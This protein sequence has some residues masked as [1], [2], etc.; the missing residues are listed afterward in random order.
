[1]NATTVTATTSRPAGNGNSVTQPVDAAIRLARAESP[2]VRQP[3]SLGSDVTQEPWQ[4]HLQ[5]TIDAL[6]ASRV[7]LATEPFDEVRR[8][9]YL[10]LL[11]LIAED[12][13][14]AVKPI[15]SLESREQEFWSHHLHGLALYLDRDGMP[16]RDRRV[17]LALRELREAASYLAETSTLDL[18]G[19]AFCSAVDSYGVY[20]VFKANEF[21]PDQEV[22]LYVE[23]DS[24]SSKRAADGYVTSLQGSYQ[25][26]DATGRRVGDHTFPIEQETCRNRRR[27]YFIPYRMWMPK[28]IYPGN[29]VL[30]LTI[31]DTP[32]QKFGQSSVQFSIKP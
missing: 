9:A 21:E 2:V 30:Q 7:E 13:D 26:F 17:A 3:V 11:H 18:R 4:V 10:R 16:V 29:Y 1:M 6:A 20:T 25:I 15:E 12:T 22:L 32:A 8:A 19:L 5:E 27:D 31:E 14:S 23:V 28:K 24:F